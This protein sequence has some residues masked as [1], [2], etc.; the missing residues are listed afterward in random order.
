[1]DKVEEM[2]R[3]IIRR[4]SPG[5]RLKLACEMSDL[6]HQLA[7]AGWQHRHPDW[8]PQRIYRAMAFSAAGIPDPD[9]LAE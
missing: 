5:D 1:M 9:P 8:S 2:Q 7:F 6:A 4:M 3:E